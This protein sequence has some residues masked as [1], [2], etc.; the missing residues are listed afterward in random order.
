MARRQ[1]PT[2]TA[3]P[4]DS[5]TLMAEH[6]EKESALAS[7]ESGSQLEAKESQHGSHDNPE[8]ALE[9]T[10]QVSTVSMN[11]GSCDPEESSAGQ[12]PGKLSKIFF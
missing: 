8:T 12:S 3:I 7:S 4:G 2:K 6:K 10:G 1:A 9:K 5:S 11:Q